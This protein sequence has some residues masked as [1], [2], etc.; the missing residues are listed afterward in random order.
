MNQAVP[1]TR[2]AVQLIR[3]GATALDLGWTDSMFDSVCRT[4][5]IA[6]PKPA[7]KPVD[8]PA[9]QRCGDVTFNK[10][11]GETVRSHIAVTLPAMQSAVFKVLYERLAADNLEFIS[12]TNVAELIPLDTS[13]RNIVF[14]MTRL[15][16]RLAPLKCWIERKFGQNGGYRLRVEA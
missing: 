11:S 2:S 13:P 12:A 10:H 16:D 8:T 5:S 6:R 9:I 15:E 7:P 3:N 14:T 1:Y 4:H